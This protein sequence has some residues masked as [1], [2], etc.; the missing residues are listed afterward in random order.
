V[1]RITRPERTVDREPSD[2]AAEIAVT[3]QN[4]SAR[5][6]SRADARP[7]R[8]K[9]RVT[10]TAGITL[11]G[12][13]ENVRGAVAVDRHAHLATQ[14][15]AQLLEKWIVLPAG[16]IRRPDCALIRPV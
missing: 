14:R 15:R 9:N 12:F 4:F 7:D 2:R 10:R 11:P 8:E 13:A 3:A 6:Y 5:E 16:N 1:L